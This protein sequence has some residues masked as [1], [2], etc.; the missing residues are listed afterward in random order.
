MA[1][2]DKFQFTRTDKN[3]M[4]DFAHSIFCFLIGP[5]LSGVLFLVWNSTEPL[6]SDSGQFRVFQ[7]AKKHLRLLSLLPV[8]C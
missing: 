8:R 6:K 7:S 2:D 3:V 1:S 4:S 5:I